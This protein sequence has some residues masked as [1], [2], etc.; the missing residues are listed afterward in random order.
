[1]FKFILTGI[2]FAVCFDMSAQ[3]SNWQN[4]DL[5]KDSVFGISTEKAYALLKYKKPK[6]VIVAVIDGGIDTSHEDLSQI[7]WRNRR[8]QANNGIDDDRNGYSDDIHGWNFIGG[9][10]G[11]VNYDNL[12]LTRQLRE[13]SPFFD[14]ISHSRVPQE[15]QMSYQAFRKMKSIY[16]REL[17][18]A[19]TMIDKIN[20]IR[21]VLDSIED[22]IG[23]RNPSQNDFMTYKPENDEQK[24]LVERMLVE[25]RTQADYKKI[26][27]NVTDVYKYYKDKVDYGLNLDFDPRP[28]IGDNYSNPHQ[29]FYGNNDVCGPN[30]QH[31]THVAG[32]IGAVRDNERGIKGVA[33]HIQIMAIRVVPNGDERDKDVANA[34]R[35]AADN[36]ASIINMSFGKRFSSEKPVVDE[37]VKYA[38]SKDVLLVHAAGNEG[39][40]LDDPENHVFPNSLFADGSGIGDAWIEVG[41]SGK[42]NDSTLVATFSNYGQKYV[43]VFAPGIRIYSCIP[44][45]QYEYLDGTSM[46]APVVAGLAALI[47]EYYPH[48]KAT[49]VK[50]IVMKSVIKSKYLIKMC[51]TGGV[52]NAYNAL[53]LAAHYK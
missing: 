3:V 23:N 46:A 42:K 43:D 27:Q 34:I 14:S 36:G 24:D 33:D 13:K 38:L 31:G 17:E 29:M 28:L 20:R 30:A 5:E 6:I 22:H 39:K 48:L 25:F 8:E 7:I 51:K 4:L 1:M 41:A 10:V 19:Y 21:I 35:Y 49:Q 53:S 37:A 40:D 15:Y 12:E 26:K 52:I 2:L 9:R 18:S 47:R 44:G 16:D 32:V 45:S 11:N 50:D